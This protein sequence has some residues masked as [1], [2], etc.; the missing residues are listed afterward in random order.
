MLIC[1]LV[2][3]VH[4]YMK[5]RSLK[6]W[7]NRVFMNNYR[8]CKRYLD[9]IMSRYHQNRLLN[10]LTLEGTSS[11]LQNLPSCDG[12]TD[13][14]FCER[15]IT[16]QYKRVKK[17]QIRAYV[18][19]LWSYEWSIHGHVHFLRKVTSRRQSECFVTFPWFIF[20]RSNVFASRVW[21]V[22]EEITGKIPSWLQKFR[23]PKVW[24]RSGLKPFPTQFMRGKAIITIINSNFQ[25]MANSHFY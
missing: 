3:M 10:L 11:E 2:S 7:G 20:S 16:G 13:R 14:L 5:W 12:D 21:R 8:I 22:R 9:K 19:G 24:T 23:L 6:S 15:K 17:A 1:S 25:K 18:H 4:G